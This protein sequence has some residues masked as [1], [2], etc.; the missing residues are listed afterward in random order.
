M[1]AQWDPIVSRD[2]HDHGPTAHAQARGRRHHGGA[3]GVVDDR[4]ACTRTR[5]RARAPRSPS[6]ERLRSRTPRCCRASC[7][8][9][10]RTGSRWSRRSRIAF[11]SAAMPRRCRP[12]SRSKPTRS[13]RRR[14]PT[15]RRRARCSQFVAHDIRSVDLPLGWAGYE[16]HAPDVVLANRYADD[17]DKVGLLLALCA[18][19]K[20]D[21]R[22]GVRAH[23][24][25]ARDRDRA[26]GRAVRP[27]D[28]EAHDRRQ[29]R[30]ARSRRRERPV[31]RRVR[32][33][34]QPRA[35]R[36]RRR[37]RTRQARRSIR[38]R[39]SRSVAAHVHARPANGDLDA[40][41]HVRPDRLVRATGRRRRCARSRART[42]ISV[43]SA[44]GDRRGERRDTGTRFA[45][46][47]GDGP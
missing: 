32:G 14:R 10:R 40:N 23:R 25:G 20:L 3:V 15:P 19:E 13:S 45:T 36:R 7:T 4:P 8:A 33:P 27:R 24:Q 17:R 30:L 6:R 34:G 38:R 37:R 44:V 2:R 39:R 1:L 35:T 12:R 21:G 41:Y 5:S 26:D 18:S 46:P 43:F 22:A 42:A 28:R 16:P 9:S 11:L 47:C 29:G 31:R